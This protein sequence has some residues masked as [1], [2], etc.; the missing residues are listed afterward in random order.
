MFIIIFCR[1]LNGRRSLRSTG[2][3][4]PVA[5]PKSWLECLAGRYNIWR[6]FFIMDL[7]NGRDMVTTDQDRASAEGRLNRT[8]GK[9]EQTVTLGVFRL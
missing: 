3:A 9:M 5:G 6:N 1:R 4:F 2:A 8:L 7:I